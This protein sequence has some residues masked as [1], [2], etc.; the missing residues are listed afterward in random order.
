VTDAEKREL[1]DG[2]ARRIE[3][4][5]RLQAAGLVCR[6]GEFHP[7]VHYPPITRY[8]ARTEEEVF[9]GYTLPADGLFDV[10]AHLPFC[11][12]RCLFCHYPAKY[13]A[14]EAE[15]DR[16]LAAIDREM[17]LVLGRLGLARLAA[18][19]ILVGGGTPTDLTPAQLDRFL[20]SFTARLDRARCTQ[21]SYDV[22]PATLV[23]PDG[24]ERLRILRSHGVDRLTIG[25]QSFDDHTLRVMN[26][27]HGAREALDSIENA[28]ALGF[29]LNLDLIF[30]HPGDT[31]QSWLAT[32]ERAAS[33][34]VEEIQMYR[35]KVE[36][37]GDLQG[38]I[39]RY[40]ASDG[41]T[42]PAPAEALHMKAAAIDLLARLGYR[43]NLRRVFTR[44]RRHYSHY[45]HNPCC[46]LKDQ[47]GFGLTGYS[48][49]RDRFAL[50]T[51]DF[52]EYHRRIGEGRLPLNRGLVRSEDDQVRWSIM[53][54]L[55]NRSVR[56]RLFR[57]RTGL[58]LD[59]VFREK[60]RALAEHGLV[61]EDERELALTPLGA[62]FA[63]EVATSFAAPEYLPFPPGAYADG[64]L[65]PYR[66]QSWR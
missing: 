48:T 44:E 61:V 28:R 23:G 32:V 47:I 5:R 40:L 4:L 51:Q 57:E 11:E 17:E 50:N 66:H 10:Y 46:E 21:F 53:L 14:R 20:A 8:P 39:K 49:L 16:Y 55:K 6:T 65:N 15:K 41:G 12:R 19:S 42:A 13:G 34:G 26:R 31:M 1:L 18:R 22:D 33:V 52:D 45:A 63:D 35:L 54:P 37:Y 25:V 3:D 30:G 24:L 7:S 43:E 64:P 38:N 58:S 9:A 2:A 29:Q 60:I 27:P 36:A 56:K 62:F 59:G